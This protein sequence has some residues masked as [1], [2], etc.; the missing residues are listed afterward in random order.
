MFHWIRSCCL[1]G[2][3]EK[4]CQISSWASNQELNTSHISTKGGQGGQKNTKS[5]SLTPF[6]LSD[7][8]PDVSK[9]KMHSIPITIHSEPQWSLWVSLSCW[10]VPLFGGKIARDFKPLNIMKQTLQ[11]LWHCFACIL[12]CF[13]P[14]ISSD[15]GCD[16]GCRWRCLCCSGLEWLRHANIY[17]IYIY[18]VKNMKK[19]EIVSCSV[20]QTQVSPGE[21]SGITGFCVHVVVSDTFWSLWR[22]RGTMCPNPRSNTPRIRCLNCF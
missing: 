21:I 7:F 2:K 6:Q 12:H 18:M 20:I 3:E 5:C 1:G 19:H 8:E 10:L 14:P 17:I 9:H 22:W 16:R 13:T 4:A 11:S 15:D